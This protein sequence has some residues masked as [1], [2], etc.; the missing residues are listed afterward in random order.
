MTLNNRDLES[1]VNIKCTPS[2]IYIL[3]SLQHAL[4]N[5]IL[6]SQLQTA[7]PPPEGCLLTTLITNQITIKPNKHGLPQMITTKS[8]VSQKA[9]QKRALQRCIEGCALLSILTRIPDV[10]SQERKP[11]KVSLPKN[12]IS[13][14]RT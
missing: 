6:Y 12:L 2:S 8:T 11:K 13:P 1:V 3:F 5:A 7:H 4:E 9:V 10:R 14:R